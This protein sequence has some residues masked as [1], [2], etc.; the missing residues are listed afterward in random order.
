MYKLVLVARKDLKMSA[1]KLA[2][3]CGHA[4]LA[5]VNKTKRKS[6]VENWQFSGEPIIVL[7][8]SDL[9]QLMKIKHLAEDISIIT[10]VVRDAGLTQVEPGSITVLALGINK[11][12]LLDKICC[13][14]KLY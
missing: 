6:V 7:K 1:G 12:T 10:S 4:V 5:A 3:Q 13:R 8:C 14:L 2:A 9:K 11:I